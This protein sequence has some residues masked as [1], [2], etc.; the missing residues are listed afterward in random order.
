MLIESR[1]QL[2]RIPDQSLIVK[3]QG[4]KGEYICA[5]RDSVGS[6]EMIYIPIGKAITINTSFINSKKLNAWWFNPRSAESIIIGTLANKLIMDFTTP[7]I[8][9]ENDWVLII[10]N[11]KNNYRIPSLK[12]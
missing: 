5:F 8:G 2:N 3:G 12:K 10:D 9:F 7:T 4:E 11:A 6:Y 1:P